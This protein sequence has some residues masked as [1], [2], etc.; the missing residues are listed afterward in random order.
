VDFVSNQNYQ[1]REVKQINPAANSEITIRATLAT[2]NEYISPIIDSSRFGAVVVRNIVNNV[3][4]GET[5]AKGGD[6]EG[7]YITRRVNLA[8]GFDASTLKVFLNVN[9]P[10]GTDIKVY[11]R[12]LS[13]YDSTDF[14]DR[15]Y[16][17]MSRVELG[18]NSTTDLNT[19]IEEQ[20]LAEDITYTG[21][22]GVG[23]KY[24]DFKSFAI[25]VVFLS[26]DEAFVPRISSLRAVA[27][28]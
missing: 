19:F 7:R 26:S 16:V 1:F 24:T 18:G 10:A 27:L 20:Y 5:T 13:K 12:V 4:S 8:E 17:E 15:P 11:Y 9:R 14:A 28:S 21:T 6:A 25:K 3:S 2:E 22:A 23:G